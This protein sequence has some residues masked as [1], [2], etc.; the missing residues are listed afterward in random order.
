MAELMGHASVQIT[1][2]RYSHVMPHMAAALAD[3]MDAAYVAAEPARAPGA[4]TE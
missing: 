1:L 3:R 4:G 2:D